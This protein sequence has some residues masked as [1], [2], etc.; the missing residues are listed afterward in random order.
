MLEG[1]KKFYY[2]D[3]FLCGYTLLGEGEDEEENTKELLAH[4][5]KINASDIIVKIVFE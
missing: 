1:W 5:N 3:K 4:E 2:K